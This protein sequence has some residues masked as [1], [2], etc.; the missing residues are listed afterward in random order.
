MKY[1]SSFSSPFI[2]SNKITDFN[3]LWSL[4]FVQDYSEMLC[5]W[6]K[7]CLIN[8]LFFAHIALVEA[9]EIRFLCSS[10]WSF[11]AEAVNRGRVEAVGDQK[12]VP[13]VITMTILNLDATS[14]IFP[15]NFN[16]AIVIGCDSLGTCI[17]SISLRKIWHSDVAYFFPRQ[18][19]K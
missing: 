1:F 15:E 8:I 7:K 12:R 18:K 10:T 3:L 17:R 19:W 2:I 6:R 11:L 4:Q 14:N 5:I 9:V 13:T 16:S